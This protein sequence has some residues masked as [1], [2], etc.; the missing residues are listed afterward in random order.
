[1]LT[2]KK[3]ERLTKPGRYGDERTL[4][5]LVAPGGSKSWVQRIYVYSRRK[6]LGLGPWP[7]VTV[8]EARAAAFDNRRIVQQ[9]GDPSIKQRTRAVPTVQE[10]AERFYTEHLPTWKD[11]R[12]AKDW[13]VLLQQYIFQTCGQV[14]VDKLT[15]E[16]LLKAL[17][18]IWGRLP[19]SARKCK[20][21]VRVILE[22]AMGHGYVQHNVAEEINGALAKQPNTSAHM[23]AAPYKGIPA[24]L[25]AIRHAPTTEAARLCVEFLLMTAT[26]SQEARLAT[27]EEID[28]DT[29]TWT[30]PA[31][32][33]K[34]Q[35]AHRVP[36]SETALAVLTKAKALGSVRWVFP[37]P[38]KDEA[39]GEATLRKVLK[40][41]G[42]KKET[43]VHGF[44]S[45]FRTWAGEETTAPHDVLEACLAHAVG[46][47]VSRAY[48]RGDLLEKRRPIMHAWG[49]F[50]VGRPV[51]LRR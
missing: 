32:R 48:A 43:T 15:R 28:W 42:V 11:G 46:S 49:R 8:D 35:Q 45:S 18:P 17:K 24:I 34:M 7:V 16:H 14:P 39:L 19:E 25:S 31:P 29:K 12:A 13:L 40:D 41:A 5:L 37:S 36:L 23:K 51:L 27:W 4:Y 38:L 33:M 9:G 3:I 20:G 47:S 22:W 2:D 21:R 44:R 1:M 26:R 50:V 6:E 30:I 10:A